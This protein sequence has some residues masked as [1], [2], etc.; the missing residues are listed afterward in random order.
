MF[1]FILGNPEINENTENINEN[2][3]DCAYLEFSRADPGAL[4][5]KLGS[6]DF[7]QTLSANK[8]E[9][10]GI[11]LVVSALNVCSGL[12]AFINDPKINENTSYK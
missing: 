10:F 1:S 8:S 2:K 7:K 12:F 3:S 4:W 6:W 11:L 5:C 9:K